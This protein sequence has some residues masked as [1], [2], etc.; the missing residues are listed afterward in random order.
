MF[1]FY[2]NKLQHTSELGLISYS[3]LIQGAFQM[4]LGKG[5]DSSVLFASI[6]DLNKVPRA[7]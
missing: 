4:Q 5:D 7:E 1:A 3:Q 6:T 2:A